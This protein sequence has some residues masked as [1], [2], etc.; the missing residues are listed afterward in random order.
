MIDHLSRDELAKLASSGG[1][2]DIHVADRSA[3]DL[4]F[5]A[6]NMVQGSRFIIRG[7]ASFTLE[8]LSFIARSGNGTVLFQG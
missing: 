3:E 1:G 4:S 8:E 7:P 5:I 2:L 6:R